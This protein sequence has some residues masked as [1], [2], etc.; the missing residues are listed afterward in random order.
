MNRQSLSESEKTEWVE[1]FENYDLSAAAFCREFSLPYA[2]FLKWRRELPSSPDGAAGN[3]GGPEPPATVE[4]LEVIAGSSQ[5]QTPTHCV[6]AE[7]EL[8]AGYMLR[9]YRADNQ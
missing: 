7:L 9:V 5:P 1:L 4:F 3:G 2:S 6:L 8:G